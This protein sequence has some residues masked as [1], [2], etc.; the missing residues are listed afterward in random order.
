[1]KDFIGSASAAALGFITADVPGAIAGYKAYKSYQKRMPPLRHADK[2][3]RHSIAGS[4]AAGF[5]PIYK[6]VFDAQSLPH[7]RKSSTSS[8][9]SRSSRRSSVVFKSSAKTSDKVIASRSSNVSSARKGKHRVKKLHKKTPRVKVSRKL[10]QKVEKVI[11]GNDP[12]GYYQSYSWHIITEPTTNAQSVTLLNPMVSIDGVQGSYF[13]PT[14]VLNAASI[15]WNTKVPIPNP[16]YNDVAGGIPSNFNYNNVKINVIK[17]W[18]TNKFRNNTQRN[19]YINI[20]TCVRKTNGTATDAKTEWEAAI[21]QDQNAGVAIGG[22]KG[23]PAVV[24]LPSSSTL[25]ITPS[26][27]KSLYNNWDIELTKIYLKPGEEYVHT[28]TGPS[29]MYDYRKFFAGN[30]A[31]TMPKGSVSIFCTAYVDMI[32]A[33]TTGVGRIAETNTAGYQVIVENN[34]YLKC[35]IPAQAGIYWSNFPLGPQPSPAQGVPNAGNT[36][37]L[38][39]KRDAY[40]FDMVLPVALSGNAVRVDIEGPQTLIVNP[41]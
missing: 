13:T 25:Y 8:A 1:M 12:K 33:T 2:R 27:S 38:G 14:Q 5:T 17:Q 41:T 7:K 16:T 11:E 40:C 31:W 28:T 29:K 10:R 19:Y 26:V 18:A 36:T 22:Q 34:Y 32:G 15:L 24:T 6:N 21:T 39:Q 3:R 35:E 23:N 4:S 30:V 20:Y 9:S 37:S